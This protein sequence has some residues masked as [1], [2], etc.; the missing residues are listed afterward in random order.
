LGRYKIK[1]TNYSS[2]IG[3]LN[4]TKHLINNIEIDLCN[5][6]KIKKFYI[7]ELEIKLDNEVSLISLGIKNDFECFIKDYEEIKNN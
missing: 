5:N 6:I 7:G 4:S 3:T 2:R 1:N